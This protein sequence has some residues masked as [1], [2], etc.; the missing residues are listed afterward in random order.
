[1]QTT[2]MFLEYIEILPTHGLGLVASSLW[3]KFL[4]DFPLADFICCSDFDSSSYFPLG[5]SKLLPEPIHSQ[6]LVLLYF[7]W[8]TLYLPLCH[9]GHAV[10]HFLFYVSPHKNANQMRETALFTYSCI[11]HTRGRVPT[12]CQ[13]SLNGTQMNVNTLEEGTRG[14]NQNCMICHH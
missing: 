13:Y 7:C 8:H 3:D 4:P 10:I 11:S 6:S 9:I 14:G 2:F 12:I 5:Q 1:M